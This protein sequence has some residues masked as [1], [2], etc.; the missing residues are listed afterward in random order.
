MY[1]I[2]IFG[3]EAETKYFHTEKEARAYADY[4]DDGNAEIYMITESQS[5]VRSVERIA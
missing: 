4:M 3:E 2:D 5:A 1:R